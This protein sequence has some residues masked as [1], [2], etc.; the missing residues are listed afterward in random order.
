MKIL[1][2]T[3][4]LNV[5]GITSYVLALSKILASRGHRLTVA[6]SGGV[7]EA[8]VSGPGLA[9]WRVP[10]GTSA[11]FS[12][13]VARAIRELS[14]RLREEPVDLLHA[15][16]R[17]GQVAAAR[18][19]H[20]LRIPYVTTWHGFYR[21]NLGRWLWPCTGA[22]TI[23]I[24]EPVRQHLIRDFR[25]P[26][27]RTRLIMNGVDV[28]HFAKRLAPDD[29]ARYRERLG[30]LPDQ[31]VIGGVGRLASGGVK[32]FDL[33]LA[34]ASRLIGEWPELHVLV[35]G[36]GP[37][38]PAL[39]EMVRR[40]G[41]DARAH[42]T[43]A[44]VDTRLPLAAMDVFVF[45][46]RWPEAFGLSL[47]EAMAAGKPL[48]ATRIGAVPDIVE[49]GRTGLLVASGDVEA[50]REGMGQAAQDAVRQTFTLEQMTAQVEAVY[51]E[52]VT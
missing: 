14:R 27:G 23:A 41:L 50:L 40:L 29:V 39:E 6:S 7:R 47:V 28:A 22:L 9:H 45:P 44:V 43:G 38:R 36:D 42:F 16:T 1:Q 15:H 12:L 24:S 26:P 10:L 49:D 2:V 3:S 25:V 11:E 46:V 21:R 13:P 19:S 32:G 18:L 30:I 20:V 17:V 35:V 4:H 31:P 52:L 5:G 48:V 51:R 33:L 37:K 8:E 34:A